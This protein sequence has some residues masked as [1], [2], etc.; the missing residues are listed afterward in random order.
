[1]KKTKTI[2]FTDGTTFH[3][4]LRFSYGP[5]YSGVKDDQLQELRKKFEDLAVVIIDEMSLVGPDA[6]YNVHRRLKDIL[7]VDAP[8]ADRAIMLVGDL[9]QI[10]PVKANYIF[11]KPSNEQNKALHNSK[12]NLWKSCSN[13]ELITNKRQGIGPWTDTLN[14]IRFGEQTEDDVAMLEERRTTKFERDFDDA[15][16]INYAN[17]AVNECNQKIMESTLKTKTIT[18]PAKIVPKHGKIV[19]IKNGFVEETRLQEFLELKKGCRVI[20]V[21]NKDIYDNLVNGVSGTVVDFLWRKRSGADNSHVVAVLVQFDDPTVGQN[22][23]RKHKDLH[24]S[25]KSNN[26]VPIFQAKQIPHKKHSDMVS[27]DQFPLNLVY[28][29]TSHKIQGGQL[30]DIDVVCHGR[31][32]NRSLPKGCGYVM[33]SRCTSIENVFID[34]NFDVVKDCKPDPHALDEAKRLSNCCLANSFSKEKFDLFYVNMVSESHM[35]DVQYD[36]FA[37]QSSLVCLVQTGFKAEDVKQWPGW[38]CLPHASRGYG[39][40]V[41]VF[42]KNKEEENYGY[43]LNEKRSEEDFQIVQMLMKKKQFQIFV[44]YA[45]QG[46]NMQNLSQ[47]INAMLVN[48]YEIVLLGDLNFNFYE[49]KENHLKEY[50]TSILGLK[51]ILTGPTFVRSGNTIDQVYVPEHLE[52]VIKFRFNY[53]SDHMSFNISFV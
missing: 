23:R 49:K 51:Q 37:K 41:C 20:H 39:K 34:E 50:L 35:L 1:M 53:Y 4:G 38:K 8:F 27:V 43:T 21:I 25:I 45:S 36:P 9:M 19:Q 28:S 2:Y 11:Q 14:R 5:E 26:A 52:E 33:L 42:S 13:V 16:H 10:K 29:S 32:G 18:M 47:A 12:Y 24:N 22:L 30:K 31:L 44:V 40:G 46:A 3:T 15:F 6:F 48:D 17:N 7:Q